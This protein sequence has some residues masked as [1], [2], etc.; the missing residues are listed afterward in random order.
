[1]VTR[2]KSD[3]TW[4]FFF[5]FNA[6]QTD[7]TSSDAVAFSG[8]LVSKNGVGGGNINVTLRRQLNPISRME[9]SQALFFFFASFF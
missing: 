4:S 2:R 7:I 8:M 1:M 3:G 9:V 6:C 5:F